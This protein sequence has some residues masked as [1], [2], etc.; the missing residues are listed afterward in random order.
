MAN[1]E[2]KSK[3]E[4]MALASDLQNRTNDLSSQ[5]DTLKSSIGGV[6]DFDGIPLSSYA[7]TLQSNLDALKKDF[8]V[9]TNNIN[10]YS[11]NIV[12][13]DVDDFN[14]QGGGFI[15]NLISSLPGTSIKLPAGLGR[16]YTY[17]GW[18][19]ITN[20]SSMQYKLREDAGMNFDSEGFG[21]INGRYVIATTTT[22]GKVGDYVDIV[23]DNGNVLHCIIGD[24]KN[25]DDPGCNKWGHLD[26]QCV[27]EFVVDKGSWYGK[28]DNPGNPSN[29]PEWKHSVVEVI[30]RGN[31]WETEIAS[32][33]TSV[34]INPAMAAAPLATT[35]VSGVLTK[36]DSKNVSGGNASSSSSQIQNDLPKPATPEPKQEVQTAAPEVVSEPQIVNQPETPPEPQIVNQPEPQ[37][38]QPIVNN[39]EPQPEQPAAPAA[40]TPGNVGGYASKPESGFVVSG[41]HKTY[42]LSDGDLNLL[43]AIVAAESDKSADDALAVASTI[44]NRCE[45]PAWESCGGS[46][47]IKQAT[48]SGQFVVYETGKYKEFM[49]GNVPSSVAQAVLDA[50]GGVRNHQYLSFRANS[51]ASYSSNMITP[52]GNRYR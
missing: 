39:P 12:N 40:P 23:Q 25:Q 38:E 7:N 26:G 43:M 17:M 51:S 29:H 24:I 50:L 13:F 37:P 11:N 8:Q 6:F 31:Y 28:K 21:I 20:K 16:A 15:S 35:L 41:G 49:N 5:L 3:N 33:T 44:L 18:Q 4:L 9:V 30:N 2:V 14:A 34:S 32:K 19:M 1:V 48:A 46:N 36:D 47:P 22:Y 52:D 42:S 45:S 10:N 27:V